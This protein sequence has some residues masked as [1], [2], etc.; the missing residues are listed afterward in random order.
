MTL[1][2]PARRK[3]NLFYIGMSI[4]VSRVYLYCSLSY[5][6]ESCN[7]TPKKKICCYPDQKHVLLGQYESQLIYA[8][9]FNGSPLIISSISCV[10]KHPAYPGTTYNTR[11]HTHAHSSPR[12]FINKYVYWRAF[13][14]P[15]YLSRH[16]IVVIICRYAELP[17]ELSCRSAT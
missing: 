16:T 5:D 2:Y 11:I 9:C 15:C 3:S 4:P 13:I 10:T 17:F 14:P 8:L 12:C 6:D 7:E 1:C